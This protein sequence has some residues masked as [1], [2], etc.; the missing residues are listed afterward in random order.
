MP[1][2]G[3]Q[4]V[5][6]EPVRRFV[7]HLS[8][9]RGLSPQTA[10][11]YRDDLRQ[12]FAYLDRRQLEFDRIDHRVLR[13]FLASLAGICVAASLARKLSTLRTFYRWAEREGLAAGNPALRLRAPK[14]AR[15]LPEMARPEE[16]IA[17]LE[18]AEDG[19]PLG[20]RD[21][22]LF[23]L[24]YSSGLRASEICGLD[25]PDLDLTQALVRVLGKGNRERVVPVGRC[26]LEA[27][28]R[29]LVARPALCATSEPAMFV[30]RRGRRLERRALGARLNRTV[31]RAAV[32]RRMHPHLLRHC[33]ATHLLE[34]GADLRSIQELLGHASLATTQRYTHVD[35]RH[36]MEVYDRAHPKA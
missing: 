11:A 9:E 24:L 30:D 3:Q 28:E 12:L 20:I 19:T 21:R 6:A 13:A 25:L 35:L 8:T 10:R 1:P 16:V 22:A 27:L 36:V 2:D 18:A 5:D 33:F 29:Y 31:L 17:V 26:A 32:G 23:E 7:S 4:V 34:N 15:R 14:I